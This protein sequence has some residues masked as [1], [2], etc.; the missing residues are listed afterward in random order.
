MEN[1]AQVDKI[2][3]PQDCR[4]KISKGMYYLYDLLIPLLLSSHTTLSVYCYIFWPDHFNQDNGPRFIIS[5]D[6][7]HCPVQEP[8]HPDLRLDKSFFSHK[9]GSAG[10]NYEVAISIFE[11]QVVWVSGPHPAATPDIIVFRKENGLRSLIQPGKLIVADECYLG[12]AS[13]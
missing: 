8:N 5:V 7:T 10:V 2:L 13:I 1:C 4:T 12:E 6:G 3:F 11:S 9:F